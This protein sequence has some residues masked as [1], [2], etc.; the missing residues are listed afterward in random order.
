MYIIKDGMFLNSS[1]YLG[2]ILFKYID[3]LFNNNITKTKSY[4]KVIF[5][6]IT[7]NI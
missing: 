4:M 7:F 1:T 2:Q 5:K 6:L 3:F